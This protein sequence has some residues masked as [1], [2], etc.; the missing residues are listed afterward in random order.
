[1]VEFVGE[2]HALCSKW[3]Q[4]LCCDFFEYAKTSVVL[5]VHDTIGS[6]MELSYS[7]LQLLL[8]ELTME[9]KQRKRT[10]ET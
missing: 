3:H 7:M 4:A 9:L 1:V 2:I 10:T 5:R 6:N 8:I